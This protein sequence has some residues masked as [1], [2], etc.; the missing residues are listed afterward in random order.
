MNLI[1]VNKTFFTLF[2]VSSS[3]S[4]APLVPSRPPRQRPGRR[5]APPAPSRTRPWPPTKSEIFYENEAMN[6]LL[7]F[8]DIEEEIDYLFMLI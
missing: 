6:L 3:S 7:R 8:S 5:P 1:Q 4:P 2:P